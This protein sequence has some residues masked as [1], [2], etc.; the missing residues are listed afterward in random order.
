MASLKDQGF[1]APDE[2][3]RRKTEL[4][5]AMKKRHALNLERYRFSGFLLRTKAISKKKVRKKE[6]ELKQKRRESFK[7]RKENI[8]SLNWR[9]KGSGHLKKN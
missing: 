1:I 2:F 7:K 9:R 3:E 6:N 8:N 4:L 5:N